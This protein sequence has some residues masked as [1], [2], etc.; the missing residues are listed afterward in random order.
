M[1]HPTPFILY[2]APNGAV[3]VSVIFKDETLWMTQKALAELF[4]VKVPAIA[5]HLKNIF[6]SGEL[7]EASV[8]SILE[9]TAGD[10]KDYATR[11]SQKQLTPGATLRN[12][13]TVQQ[14]GRREVESHSLE[15]IIAVECM[16]S[17]ATCKDY[18]Q[19]RNGDSRRHAHLKVCAKT[20]VR[21]RE[22]A[23]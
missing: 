3:R 1:S 12:F 11:Y 21:P 9:T 18:L 23:G 5:K 7:A 19:V 2:T 13:R 22:V 8:V 6:S 10:G 4:G 20:P 17:G 14:E 15:A 16:T